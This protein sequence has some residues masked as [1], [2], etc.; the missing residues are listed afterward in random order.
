MKIHKKEIN[1]QKKRNFF[2]DRISPL[3]NTENPSR[4]KNLIQKKKSQSQLKKRTIPE[5]K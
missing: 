4:K 5:K 2:F 1:F 3:K